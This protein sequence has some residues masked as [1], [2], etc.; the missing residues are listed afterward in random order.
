MRVD[1]DTWGWIGLYREQGRP[2]F[3]DRDIGVVAGLSGALGQAMREHARA[4]SHPAAGA[5]ARGAGLMLFA[6][7]GEL[8]SMN[9]DARAWIEEFPPDAGKAG[10][11]DTVTPE[12]RFEGRFEVRFPLVVAAA[13]MRARALAE[14]RDHGTA[15]ARLRSSASG[16]WLVC[17]A[18]CLRDAGG[19]LADT[20]LTIEPAA[21]A[22]IAPI[23]IQAHELTAREQEI[24]QLI[25]QGVGT[26]EIAQRLHLSTHTVRGY[27]K[28]IFEK[29]SV[30]S[31][32][33]LV[34]RLFAEHYA[35][36]HTDPDA[37]E[38]FGI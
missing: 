3:D 4:E 35:A 37:Q 1:G 27:V 19:E 10:R 15:R 34:A 6:P 16:R 20:A 12:G 22:E 25:T 29:V 28:G 8:I 14:D 24:T 5:A 17:H 36:A 23:I 32:G 21:A 9:D 31:R 18:S 11:F 26:G 7:T 13:L 2:A 38:R 30:S 33:E